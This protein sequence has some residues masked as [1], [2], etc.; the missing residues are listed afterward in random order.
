MSEKGLR[1]AGDIVIDLRLVGE[2]IFLFFF[3][4][5]FAGK[6]INARYKK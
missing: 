3:L 6:K 1:L 4:T 5:R 2:C